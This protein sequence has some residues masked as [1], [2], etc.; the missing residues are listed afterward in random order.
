MKL[1]KVVDIYGNEV[2][3]NP[4]EIVRLWPL[5]TEDGEKRRRVESTDR[6]EMTIPESEAM[7]LVCE[8]NGWD[9]TKVQY[10]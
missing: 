2:Y 4:L 1:I 9:I 8:I 10:R 3:I 7:K 6:K 5:V